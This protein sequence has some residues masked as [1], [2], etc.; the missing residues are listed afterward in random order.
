M[1]AGRPA[2][3]LLQEIGV[4]DVAEKNC[5]RLGLLL[6]MAFQ[7][8]SLIAFSQHALIDRAMRRMTGGATF[9]HRFVFENKRSALRR[10]TLRAGLVRAQKRDATTFD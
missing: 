4:I 10:M 9:A 1:A 2:R 7:T 3:P 5:P 6:E 8:E